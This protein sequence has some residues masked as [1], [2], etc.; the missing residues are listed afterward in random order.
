MGALEILGIEPARL[1][2]L[3]QARA[4]EAPN[5]IIAGVS[6]Y[7]GDGQKNHQQ[8]YIDP[9]QRCERPGHEQQRISGQER[10]DHQPGFAEDDQEQDHIDPRPVVPDQRAEMAVEMQGKVK[11]HEQQ[12]HYE[13]VRLA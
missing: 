3:E 5:R 9:A 6:G 10:R 12:F 4:E 1:P 8:M 7:C 13:P 2:V 11:N